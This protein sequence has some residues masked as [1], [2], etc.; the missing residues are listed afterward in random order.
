MDA[1]QYPFPDPVE[2]NKFQVAYL[3]LDK[4][5]NAKTRVD[6]SKF[7]IGLRNQTQNLSPLKNPSLSY[8]EFA[9][10]C[11]HILDLR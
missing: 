10:L 3:E 7:T 1:R 9:L 5:S 2:I 4:L 6:L 11:I 8:R